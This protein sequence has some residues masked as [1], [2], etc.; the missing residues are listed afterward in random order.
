MWKLVTALGIAACVMLLLWALRGVLLTPVRLGKHE[1]LTLLLRVE[2]RAPELE[3]TADALLWLLADG[4]LP[5]ELVI[6]DAGMDAETLAVARLLAR[7][8]ERVTVWEKEDS[9]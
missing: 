1:S 6:E 4:V 9:G 7:D 2:G 5:G 3:R 8:N